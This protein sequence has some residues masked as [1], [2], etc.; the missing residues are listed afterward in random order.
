MYFIR[1]RSSRVFKVFITARGF[2]WLRAFL[3]QNEDVLYKEQRTESKTSFSDTARVALR[4]CALSFYGYFFV[5]NQI[6]TAL[7][8]ICDLLAPLQQ[9]GVLIRQP[10]DE[11]N[12]VGH[13]ERN[14]V[15]TVA[16]N[17]DSEFQTIRPISGVT[18]QYQSQYVAMGK[19]RN[20]KDEAGLYPVRSVLY[21][22][23]VGQ[24]IAGYAKTLQAQQF[25]LLGTSQGRNELSWQFQY[26]M[27]V[28]GIQISCPPLLDS[29]QPL[30]EPEALLSELVFQDVTVEQ[31]TQ[32]FL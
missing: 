29:E 24:P 27:T 4:G 15:I 20:L 3:W 28:E 25:K 8:Q 21:A 19:L 1:S 16:Y 9:K 17:G 7:N 11:P 5:S 14:G 2:H 12:T 26:S 32:Y 10:A 30:T 22:L 13:L 31:Q 23:T 6:Q 18:Q